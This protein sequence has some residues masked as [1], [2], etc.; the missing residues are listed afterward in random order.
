[1]FK[2]NLFLITIFISFSVIT[3]VIKNKTRIIEK[4]Q[5]T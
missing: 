4:H 5:F 1:M 2:T 3:Q